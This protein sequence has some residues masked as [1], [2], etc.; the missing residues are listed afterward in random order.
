MLPWH[1]GKKR[2]LADLTQ[3][4]TDLQAL[5]GSDVV[6]G[7]FPLNRRTLEQLWSIRIA[8]GEWASG[9]WCIG[10]SALDLTKLNRTPNE[11]SPLG[12]FPDGFVLKNVASFG[13]ALAMS[14]QQQSLLVGQPSERLEVLLES[15]RHLKRG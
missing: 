6:F 4:I 14:E 13:C 12:G 1:P 10:S 8:N 9:E 7:S 3:L 2:L 5:P 11:W 15:I